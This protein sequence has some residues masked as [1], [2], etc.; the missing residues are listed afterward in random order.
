MTI[1][2]EVRKKFYAL[3]VLAAILLANAAVLFILLPRNFAIRS[4]C[5]VALL[6]SV[7]LSGA[8]TPLSAERGVKWSASGHLRRRLSE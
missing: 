2:T 4:L 3:R 7:G 1:P 6:I 8:L 5:L